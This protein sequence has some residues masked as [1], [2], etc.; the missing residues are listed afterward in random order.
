MRNPALTTWL[1]G[2]DGL[3]TKLRA[4]RLEAELTGGELAATHGWGKTKVSK[5][6]NGKQLPSV[7]DVK[8]WTAACGADQ[9][10]TRA[11]LD[12]LGESKVVHTSWTSRLAAGG[13]EANQRAYREILSRSVTLH[14][15]ESAL[16]PGVLQTPAVAR[17]IL[18]DSVR[19]ITGTEP[20]PAEIDRAVAQ[21][22][23]R[24]TLLYSETLDVEIIL[25]EAALRTQIAAPGEM[26]GQCDRIRSALGLPGVR[27][28]IVPLH[29]PV[30]HY[31]RPSFEVYTFEDATAIAIADLPSGVTVV[32]DPEMV[33]VHRRLFDQTW[34]DAVEGAE[35]AA[36]LDEVAQEHQRSG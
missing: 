28:G 2:P 17:A 10:T 29:L 5:I 32:E 36:L 14:A 33:D 31:L 12:L 26:V 6:E 7:A 25:T 20:D 24:S 18:H 13:Q 3:G 23:E 8:A 35:A 34:D 9:A 11:L 22:A 27:I 4:L 30:V 21:R 15:W 1:A 16:I 19:F